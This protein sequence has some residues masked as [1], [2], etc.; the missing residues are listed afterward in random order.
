MTEPKGCPACQSQRIEIDTALKY[1][2]CFNCGYYWHLDKPQ[3]VRVRKFN[4]V[5]RVTQLIRK[6]FGHAE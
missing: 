3:N 2:K 5:G 1:G 4:V 6:Y